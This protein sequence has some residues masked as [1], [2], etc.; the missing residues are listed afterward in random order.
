MLFERVRF[1]WIRYY[2]ISWA[3]IVLTVDIIIIIIIRK[4]QQ[5]QRK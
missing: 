1:R 3:H 4:Q 5:Q 2:R